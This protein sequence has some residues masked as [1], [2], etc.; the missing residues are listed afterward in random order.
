MD[1]MMF[2]P[3]QSKA[4]LSPKAKPF[5]PELQSSQKFAAHLQTALHPQGK[6]IVSKHAQDR[7]QQRGIQINESH[8]KQ[9]ADKVLEA[10]QKGVNESLVLLKDAA[11]IV[12]A[13][14]NTV[15]TAMDR[16]EARTQ[17]FTNINGTI[18]LDQ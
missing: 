2:H 13:K 14:N 16:E 10:R 3:I 5:K 4:V 12:S 7:M 6:L 8:W 1:K 17:I 11:L 15:I 9:I 18:L